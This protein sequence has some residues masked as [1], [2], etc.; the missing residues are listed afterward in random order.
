VEAAAGPSAPALPPDVPRQFLPVRKPAPAEAALLYRPMLIGAAQVHFLDLKNK[1]DVTRDLAFLTEITGE[2]V[3]VNWD[4]SAEIDIAPAGLAAEPDEDACFAG[5][6]PPAAKPRNYA[7]W[8]KNFTAWLFQNQKIVIYRSPGTGLASDAG[9]S[10]RDFR[11]RL[12]QAAREQRD[13]CAEDLRARYAPRIAAL[14]DRIRRA[15]LAVQKE[16][17]EASAQ[18]LNTVLS[19]GTTLLGAFLGRKAISATTLGRATT[20][21]RSATRAG[22]EAQD[23]ARASEN[24]AALQ[25]QL[26]GLEA[27]FQADTAAAQ[28]RLDPSTEPLD[29][30]E[31]RLKKTNI[32]LKL[33]A[34]AWTPYWQSKSGTTPAW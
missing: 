10:E 30:V 18:K 32:A 17:Q 26:A 12:Q 29:T 16:Q 11:V 21:V 8:G 23:V 5:V 33:T 2:A 3:P 27:E 20:V 28:A 24:V 22:K 4:D 6:P 34:L 14:Q 1:V 13:R 15:Q 31:I 9:E 19:V 25:Q 7:A